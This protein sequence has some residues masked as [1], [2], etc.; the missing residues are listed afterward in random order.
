MIVAW[1]VMA[2]IATAAPLTPQDVELR[3]ARRWPFSAYYPDQAQRM[4]VA[5]DV[6][7]RCLVNDKTRLENCELLS[8]TPAGRGFDDSAKRLLPDVVVD[9]VAKDGQPTAGRSITLTIEYRSTGLRSA[10]S[11]RNPSYS[12]VFK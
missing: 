7:A 9:S 11:S 2:Q 10:S 12:V 3:H 5:G 6:Q 4:G 1:L 8:V